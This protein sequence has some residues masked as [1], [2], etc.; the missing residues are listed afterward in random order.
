MVPYPTA[1]QHRRSEASH[2]KT[3]PIARRKLRVF[4][5][6]SN[7]LYLNSFQESAVDTFGTLVL[8]FRPPGKVPYRYNE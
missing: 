1:P 3:R 7:S 8:S 2:L 6:T 4:K 5:S